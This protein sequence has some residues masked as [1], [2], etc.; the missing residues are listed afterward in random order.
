MNLDVEK[1]PFD[2]FPFRAFPVGRSH[3]ALA[4][5]K[6]RWLDDWRPMMK[7]LINLIIHIHR[8]SSQYNIYI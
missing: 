4:R 7:L 3:E 1:P 8:V 2:D 6:D 5:S